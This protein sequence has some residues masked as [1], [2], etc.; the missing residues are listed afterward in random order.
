MDKSQ[1][2]YAETHEWTH[3]T[4]DEGGQRVATIGLTDHAIDHET[5]TP[6][7]I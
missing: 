4:D 6:E 1:L 5:H 2:L 3:V 7:I